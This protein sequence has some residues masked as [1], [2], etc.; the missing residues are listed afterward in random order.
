MRTLERLNLKGYTH[1]P[2]VRGR[3]SRD[4]DPHLG[5]HAW[6]TLNEALMTV[7]EDH[8]VEPL[9]SALKELDEATPQQGLRAFVWTIE[10]SI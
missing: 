9:L 8:K 6:P 10:Q 2:A 5:T 4:G 1:W 3:G 7:C